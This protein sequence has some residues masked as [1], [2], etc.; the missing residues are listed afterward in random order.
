MIKGDRDLMRITCSVNFRLL[1]D[2]AE[3]TGILTARAPNSVITFS[4]V[5]RAHTLD[6]QSASPRREDVVDYAG[7]PRRP[8]RNHIQTIPAPT[9]IR[10]VT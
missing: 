4:S 2:Y 10:S 7:R 5:G 8:S 9:I 3:P 1:E 6:A